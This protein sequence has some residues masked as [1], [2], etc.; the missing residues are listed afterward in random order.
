MRVGDDCGIS[1]SWWFMILICC[2]I[3]CCIQYCC[4]KYCQP[5]QTHGPSHTGTTTAFYYN[6]D[7]DNNYVAAP[8]AAIT[9]NPNM[10]YNP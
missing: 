10:M 3:Y 7:I 6:N 1:W 8:N 4:V 5:Q 9:T 2:P